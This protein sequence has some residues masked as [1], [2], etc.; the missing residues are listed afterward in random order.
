MVSELPRKYLYW[1]GVLIDCIVYHIYNI[2]DEK[3]CTNGSIH[4]G[5]RTN[6]PSGL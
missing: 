3:R 2:K 5:Y 4:L 1:I 6:L